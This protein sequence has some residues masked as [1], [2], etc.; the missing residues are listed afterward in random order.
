MC[1]GLGN[2]NMVLDGSLAQ[3]LE[4]A[5]KSARRLRNQ[6]VHND[7][8]AFWMELLAHGRAQLRS[9]AGMEAELER[10]LASLQDELAKRERA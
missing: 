3:N 1:V 8:L 10:L 7:T 6:P 4:A 9:C 2:E 5:L